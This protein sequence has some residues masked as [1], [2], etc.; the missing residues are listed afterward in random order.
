[1]SEGS[2]SPEV[3]SPKVNNKLSRRDFLKIAALTTASAVLA[4]KIPFSSR[5]ITSSQL[6]NTSPDSSPAPSPIST[7]DKMTSQEAEFRGELTMA[8]VKEVAQASGEDAVEYQLRRVSETIKRIKE[9]VKQGSVD[10]ILT[11]EYSFAPDGRSIIL[12][13]TQDGFEIDDLSDQLL[14]EA[15]AELSKIASEN[16][17]DIY[18][19][20]FT[21]KVD[22]SE[23]PSEFIAKGERNTVLH[24][25]KE[26]KI[27]GVKRKFLPPEGNLN[28]ERAGKEYKTL[29][30]ICGE[31]SAPFLID[32]QGNP[33][34]VIP[35]WIKKDA[36]WSIFLHP[37][38]QADVNFGNFAD[39]IQAGESPINIQPQTSPDQDYNANFDPGWLYN[40]WENYYGPFLPYLQEGSPIITADVGIAAIM[41][42]DLQ[43]MK[44]YSDPKANPNFTIATIKR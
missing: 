25:N 28:V 7:P 39:Y 37:Q 43:P 15:V 8:A 26:G 3:E 36:P 41:G 23:S 27:V 34:T 9:I 1:M 21:E 12:N 32:D 16:K 29:L 10:L 31:R 18:A 22:E 13:K 44:S 24:I 42:S 35:D 38:N 14:K 40:A 6:P 17:C 19:A 20:T 30:L 11:G 2:N 4:S 33:I 5:S